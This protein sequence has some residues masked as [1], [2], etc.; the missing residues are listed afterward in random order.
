MDYKEK[1]KLYNQKYREKVKTLKDSS[2]DSSEEKESKKDTSEDS[3]KEKLDF[4]LTQKQMKTEQMTKANLKE[5]VIETLTLTSIP[6]L[7]KILYGVVSNI[8]LKK[9]NQQST[10]SKPQETALYTPDVNYSF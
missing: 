8:I 3:L 5:K 2:K 9:S 6:I 7:I 1:K 4:F 10:E